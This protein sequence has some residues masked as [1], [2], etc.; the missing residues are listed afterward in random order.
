MLTKVQYFAWCLFF[1]EICEPHGA[2]CAI[3]T[4]KKKKKTQKN[5]KKPKQYAF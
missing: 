5:K 1:A 3:Q 2:H 4:L